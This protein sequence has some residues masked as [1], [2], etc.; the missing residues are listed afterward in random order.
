MINRNRINPQV[1]EAISH[2][3]EYQQLKLLEFIN[4]LIGASQPLKNPLLKYT[5][6]IELAEL[7]L[8]KQ[9]LKDSSTI[10]GN[11]W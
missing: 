10:D 1:A 9:A 5:G 4:A 6:S 8:M 11:E 3:D 7:D 2:L